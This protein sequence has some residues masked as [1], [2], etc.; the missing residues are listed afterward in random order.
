MASLGSGLAGVIASASAVRGMLEIDLSEDP[1][2]A[3]DRAR[4][5]RSKALVR[6]RKATNKAQKAAQ[7]VIE[8]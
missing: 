4:A 8:T 3:V 7:K 2:D 1:E 6:A 5:R